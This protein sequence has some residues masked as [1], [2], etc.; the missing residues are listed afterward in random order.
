[1]M[2]GVH[3]GSPEVPEEKLAPASSPARLNLIVREGRGRLGG[4]TF[5]DLVLQRARE[6]GRRVRP[7]DGDL[8]SRTLG[9]LYPARGEHGEAIPDGASA[10]TSDEIA[11]LKAWINAELD[12]MIED[13]VSRVLDLSGGD[14]VMQ[15]VVRDL[16]LSAFCQ[17]WGIGLTNV[18]LFGP[19]IED[20]K[21]AMERF[22]SEASRGRVIFVMNG[23]VIRQGQTTEGAFDAIT[24]HPDFLAAV[25]Q[26]A[27]ALFFQRLTCMSSL[28]ERG[29]SFYDA[30]AG[31]PDRHGNKAS[32]TL[33]HMTK[34]WLARF[35]QDVAVLGLEEW[36]P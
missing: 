10:P 3:D 9:T 15:E 5:L 17:E 13:R 21:H 23:G 26:G 35:D 2:D 32:P 6:A 36:L 18:V 34:S 33:Q 30:A 14:R 12:R 4:S 31:R 25:R 28:R 7:L 20:F 19:D 22:H 27:E 8:K 29:L 11:D 1:M 24:Q 16:Q